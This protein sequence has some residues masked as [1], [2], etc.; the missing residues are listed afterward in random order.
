[1]HGQ[2]RENSKF[3]LKSGKWYRWR[4]DNLHGAVARGDEEMV[5]Q[6]LVLG[7][8][9]NVASIYDGKMVLQLCLDCGHLHIVNV[10]LSYDILY[11]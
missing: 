9:V 1:V 6:L 11:S 2:A 8:D 7:V 10:I 3:V 5:R 4:Q